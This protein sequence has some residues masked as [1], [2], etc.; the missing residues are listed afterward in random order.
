MLKAE[1]RRE[2]DRLALATTQLPAVE[3]VR[4]A[5]VRANAGESG[6]ECD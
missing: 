4:D 6:A 5:L 2:V 1:I 3:R